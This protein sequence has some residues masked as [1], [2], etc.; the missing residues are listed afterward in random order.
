MLRSPPHS[1]D[2]ADR[3]ERLLAAVRVAPVAA[4]TALVLAIVALDVGRLRH[5]RLDRPQRRPR[6]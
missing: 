5:R 2:P 6:P 3:T 1:G 4:L